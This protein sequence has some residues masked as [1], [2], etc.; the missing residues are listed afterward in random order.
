MTV[1]RTGKRQV[2]R[3]N[4]P[5]FGSPGTP[6]GRTV[7]PI[8]IYTAK[9]ARA[10]TNAALNRCGAG[11]TS[12]ISTAAGIWPTVSRDSVLWAG[13]AQSCGMTT[14]CPARADWW[15]RAQRSATCRRSGGGA[16]GHSPLAAIPISYRSCL[17]PRREYTAGCLPSRGILGR[18]SPAVV[19]QPA[20]ILASPPT[21]V[22]GRPSTSS[23]K[24][25]GCAIGNV[26]LQIPIDHRCSPSGRLPSGGDRVGHAPSGEW[27][28]EDADAERHMPGIGPE[29]H[30]EHRQDERN[31]SGDGEADADKRTDALVVHDSVLVADET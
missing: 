25:F 4:G 30:A 10:P 2:T 7:R 16:D 23:H 28:H 24:L 3:T 12:S 31:G 26:R 17:G 18:H 15:W 6:S 11:E 20:A 13:L 1:P 22:A 21:L 14:R 19:T 9:T 27:T 29:R 8:P 5:C